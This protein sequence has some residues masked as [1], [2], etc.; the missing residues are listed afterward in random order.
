MNDTILAIILAAIGSAGLFAFL[1][2]LITRHDN[3]KNV[4]DKLIML[5]KDGLR[6]QLLILITLRPQDTHEILTCAEKYFGVL[7]GDWWLTPIFN[8]WCQ[9]YDIAEPSWFNMNERG[10][11]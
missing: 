8:K 1:Q 4:E 7:K 6:T 3:K 5:E 11:G 10:D 2:F 9:T